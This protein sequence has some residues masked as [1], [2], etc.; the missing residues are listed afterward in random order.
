M[1]AL[2][3]KVLIVIH[4]LDSIPLSAFQYKIIKVFTREGHIIYPNIKHVLAL[5]LLIW[6][7]TFKSR[8]LGKREV[9]MHLSSFDDEANKIVDGSAPQPYQ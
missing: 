7:Q 1:T 2:W 3:R 4:A 6:H 8:T 5:Y 9:E